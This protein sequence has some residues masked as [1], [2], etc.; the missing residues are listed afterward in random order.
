[1]CYPVVFSDTASQN[2][3]VYVENRRFSSTLFPFARGFLS[4][5]QMTLR[6]LVFCS[7][8]QMKFIVLSAWTVY[9]LWFLTSELIGSTELLLFLPKSNSS[10]IQ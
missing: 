10:K 6:S 7:S 4:S 1:M 8:C 2:V 5:N 9:T 3:Q